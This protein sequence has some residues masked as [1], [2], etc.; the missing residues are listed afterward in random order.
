MKRMRV[1]TMMLGLMASSAVAAQ[2]QSTTR[3]G[4]DPQV[5]V[6]NNSVTPVRVY[7]QDAGGEEH[8]LGRVDRGGTSMFDVPDAMAAD[9]DF[10]I[11]V[12]PCQLRQF[13]RDPVSIRTNTLE[14]ESDETVIL[15]LERDLS[16]SKVEVRQ[17]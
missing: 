2:A 14:V 17:G 8:Q 13:S 9:G 5:F 7:L 16:R 15:W 11:V 10:E 4:D 12:R 6:A 3:T 1:V